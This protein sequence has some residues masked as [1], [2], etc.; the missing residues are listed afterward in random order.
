M[1]SVFSVPSVVKKLSGTQLIGS[2]PPA[3]AAWFGL[4]VD[5]AKVFLRDAPQLR[6]NEKA[7]K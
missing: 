4:H 5:A 2:V 1:T 6:K 7:Q 3:P